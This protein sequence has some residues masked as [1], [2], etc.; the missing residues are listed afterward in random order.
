MKNRK[1]NEFSNQVQKG[2]NISIISTEKAIFKG[3][4]IAANDGKIDITLKGTSNFEGR[5]DDYADASIDNVFRPDGL[6]EEFNGKYDDKTITR[7]EDIKKGGEI[8]LTLKDNSVWKARG[9]SFITGLTFEGNNT[10]TID[11]TEEDD[12]SVTIRNLNG[13]GTF[14]VDLNSKDH[15]DGN[16]IYI[17]KNTGSHI[18]N[19]VNGIEGGLDGKY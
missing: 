6:L 13:D 7:I 15:S 17:G 1:K 11:L 3:N 14:K 10:A 2:G 12:G 8:N 18:I 19:I 9:Q 16:M 5:M 4:V